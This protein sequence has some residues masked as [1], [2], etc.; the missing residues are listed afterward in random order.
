SADLEQGADAASKSRASPSGL[1][2]ARQELQEGRLARAV[3]A[4]HTE[5]LAS[6]DREGDVVQRPEVLVVSR[7][8]AA[9]GACQ[10]VPESSV[11]PLRPGV[12][13]PVTLRESLDPD[14]VGHGVRERPPAY[15]PFD[16]RRSRLP[17]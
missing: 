12:A 4:Y 16:E 11:T 5:R 6:T 15:A 3:V 7:S 14:R 1:G 13:K 2:D 17:P 9:Q 10:C 8:A